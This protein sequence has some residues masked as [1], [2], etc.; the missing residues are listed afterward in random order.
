MLYKLPKI[1]TSSNPLIR[2]GL[3]YLYITNV[4]I[5]T[6]WQLS[7]RPISSSNS[8]LGITLAPLYNRVSI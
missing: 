2:E 6:G 8:I 7:T 1:Q 5:R 3:A 4:T